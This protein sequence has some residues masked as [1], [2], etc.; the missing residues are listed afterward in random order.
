MANDDENEFEEDNTQELVGEADKT[1][2]EAIFNVEGRI[3]LITKSWSG[4]VPVKTINNI[5]WVRKNDEIV[6]E[7]F[8]NKAA[9]AMRV[10]IN[11]SNIITRKTDKE[12][13]KILYDAN[14]AFIFDLVNEPT[15][16]NRDYRTLA[17]SFE[18]NIELFLGLVEF[19]HGSRV[20]VNIST[21]VNT[22]PAAGSQNK[23]IFGGLFSGLGV[24][25]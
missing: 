16:K 21:G 2:T 19:G 12:C 17:K 18:H 25:K 5:K 9:G 11:E 8:I 13:K 22:Q 14:R 15:I 24:N 7:R 4:E 1:F 3:E 23:G 10:I 20:A 6:G